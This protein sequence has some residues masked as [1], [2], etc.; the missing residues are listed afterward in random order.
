[1]GCSDAVVRVVLNGYC[2]HGCDRCAGVNVYGL[3]LDVYGVR[4]AAIAAAS[5]SATAGSYGAQNSIDC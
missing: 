5:C 2:R 4:N 1:M 3:D